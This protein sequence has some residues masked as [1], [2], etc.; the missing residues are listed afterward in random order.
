MEKIDEQLIIALLNK[1]EQ[2]VC[3][4]I[5]GGANINQL[6]RQKRVVETTE[7]LVL[8]LC[9]DQIESIFMF[10]CRMDLNKVVLTLLDHNVDTDKIDKGKAFHD[11]KAR[12]PAFD[13][14]YKCRKISSHKTAQQ[15]T[16]QKEYV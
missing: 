13:M 11:Y 8:P 16:S 1:D 5:I 10:A 6:I 14:V 4:S 9:K 7:G 15:L 12:H 2:K 3:E